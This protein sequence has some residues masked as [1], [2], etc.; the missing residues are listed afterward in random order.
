MILADKII[1]LRKKNGWSQEDL[2]E[3]LD[4]S[5]QSISKWE[6]AQ[7]IPDMN[8]ILK[9]SEIFGVSTD[10]LLKDEMEMPDRTDTYIDTDTDIDPDS[11]LRQ[12]SMEEASEFLRLKEYFAPRVA[13]GVMLCILSPVLLIVLGGGSEYGTFAITDQQ[14]TGIGLVTLFILIGIAVAI[15]V[16][17]GIKLNKYEYLEK[18]PIET[19]YGIK[20]MVTERKERFKDDFTR[21][22]IIGVVL[23]VVSVIPLFIA[24]AMNGADSFWGVATIGLLL[25][26][27]AIGVFF[28]VRAC[29]I[30]G[31][32]QM[33][34][35]EGDY[36]R[37]S[38][39]R[40]G[41]FGWIAG[42]YWLTV[43]AVFLL[44]GFTRGFDSNWI[45]WPVA[46]VVFAILM[47]VLEAVT[48]KNQ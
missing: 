15:F 2:S 47:I 38:K 40:S 6:S 46:G 8:K 36:T 20:G 7:S 1:E 5:R 44:T 9:L 11:A 4:V 30:N 18:C 33:L 43:T 41:K 31:A 25:V 27:V 39:K 24:M 17:A 23:C 10:F 22:V 32:Y 19:A 3:K 37:Y 13:L 48:K 35:E 42:A 26:M 21:S 34:L 12:V 45:I 29:I 14:A 28:I 16:N